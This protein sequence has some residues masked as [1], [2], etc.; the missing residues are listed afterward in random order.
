MLR[1][2]YVLKASPTER[3]TQT[4]TG[5]DRADCDWQLEEWTQWMEAELLEWH[6]ASR[7]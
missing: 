2:S 7:N 5:W 6:V 1:I 3:H 4:F